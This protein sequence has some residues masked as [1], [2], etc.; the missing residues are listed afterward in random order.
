MD[1]TDIE[2]QKIIDLVEK[3]LVEEYQAYSK[4]MDEIIQR[5]NPPKPEKP[6]KTNI[7]MITIAPP[8]GTDKKELEKLTTRLVKWKGIDKWMYS[9]ELQKNG[10]PHSHIVIR[11]SQLKNINAELKRQNKKL[12]FNID[13]QYRTQE[14]ND[15]IKAETYITKD[16]PATYSQE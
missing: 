2:Y 16:G 15:W 7:A 12:N 6:S 11:S 1:I 5:N 4:M 13:F 9:Y 8:P 3:H 14:P 10:N